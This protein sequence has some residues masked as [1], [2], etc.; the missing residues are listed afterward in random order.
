MT[1]G[2]AP[3]TNKILIIECQV[4]EV[5]F[6]EELLHGQGLFFGGT[7]YLSWPAVKALAVCLLIGNENIF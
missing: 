2:Q 7:V 5:S 6:L 3:S 1:T 4:R